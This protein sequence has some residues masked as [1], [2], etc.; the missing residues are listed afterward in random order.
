MR[1]YALVDAYGCYASMEKIFDPSLRQKPVAVL[2]N[3]D[4]I[5]IALCAI[6][7]RLG[8][9]KF[10]PYFQI[11]KL[12]KHHNVTVKS[13]NYELYASI[14]R[15]MMNVIAEFCDNN[16]VYSIDESFQLYEN[17]VCI[18]D[19][20]K[21]GINI[22]KTVYK[23]TRMP[24]GVGFGSTMTLAKVANFAAKKLSGFNGV[25]VIDNNGLRDEILSRMKLTDIW[26]VGGQTAKKLALLGVMTPLDLARSEPKQMRKNWL[27]ASS[28]G[29]IKKQSHQER[30]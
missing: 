28:R 30:I 2:A 4:G 14:S 11:E 19:W 7:K 15:R 20:H 12:L 10:K 25:A 21:H 18:K 24:V 3:N 1:I 5:V 9:P 22:R 27:Y 6:A 23:Q 16:Y 8:I 29:M 17:Y 26:R 13:S